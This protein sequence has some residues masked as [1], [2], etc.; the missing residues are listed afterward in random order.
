MIALL[1]LY[2][3]NLDRVRSRQALGTIMSSRNDLFAFSSCL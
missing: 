2:V 3:I 1:L